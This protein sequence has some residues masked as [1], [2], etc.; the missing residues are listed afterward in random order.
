M[1]PRARAAPGFLEFSSA[2]LC[3]RQ[4]NGPT[5]PD[6]RDKGHAHSLAISHVLPRLGLPFLSDPSV[7]MPL[8]LGL[9]PKY[10]PIAKTPPSSVLCLQTGWAMRPGTP[11]CLAASSRT[12]E[13]VWREQGWP[14]TVTQVLPSPAC[15][16]S[17]FSVLSPYVPLHAEAPVVPPALS[18]AP[19]AQPADPASLPR[20]TA[21]LCQCK[22]GGHSC[23]HSPAFPALW[24]PGLCPVCSRRPGMA[25]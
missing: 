7:T 16:S 20:D 2:P 8:Y 18:Q 13:R 14:A 25:S 3:P 19:T 9:L 15:T 24:P 21:R 12:R 17:P 1:K 5:A 4:R 6:K 23:A 22:H 10:S 11:S